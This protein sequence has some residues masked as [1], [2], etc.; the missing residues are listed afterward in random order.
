MRSTSPAVLIA[1]LI[2]T[3]CKATPDANHPQV[4]TPTQPK[5]AGAAD[6]TKTG[7]A[8]ISDPV[9]AEDC[10]FRKQVADERKKNNTDNVVKHNPGSIAQP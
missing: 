5:A 10:R 1:L 3:G 2:L 9:L 6:P 7:C 8:A 4:I